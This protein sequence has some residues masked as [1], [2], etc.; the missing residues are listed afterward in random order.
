MSLETHTEFKDPLSFE[1]WDTTH[2]ATNETSIDDTMLRV[3]SAAASAEKTPELQ[4]YW[5]GQFLDMLSGFK[6]TSGG[7]IY[8][9]AGAGWSGTSLLNCFVS[10]RSGPDLDSIE[11]ILCDIGN[12]CKTLKSEGGWGQNFSWIRPRGSFIQKIGIESPGAVKFMEIYDKTSDVITSGSGQKAKA[13]KKKIR[14]GA[15]MGVLDV[16]HP[17][18]EE[19]IRAKQHGDRLQKFNLSSNCLDKFMQ[20]LIYL[21]SVKDKVSKEEFDQL[22]RWDLIFPEITHE[23]YDEEWDG[24]IS[25]WQAKGYPIEVYKTVSLTG[26]WDLIMENTYKRADPGVLFLDR[27]NYFNPLSYAEKILATNPCLRG[28]T[29]VSLK[30]GSPFQ[31]QELVDRI[32]SGEVLEVLTY[33]TATR[34]IEPDVV[35]SGQLTK[36]NAELLE[37]VL[38]D[39]KTLYVTPDHRIYTENRGWVEAQYL[40]E[41]DDIMTL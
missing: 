35:I 33:N 7:R 37:L 5:R 36:E 28:D 8:A 2:R 40:T 19:F 9:N 38:D 17:D 30:D 31:I 41:D 13:G 4:E 20:T 12:Q 32:N 3:A 22:D 16:W 14:K 10:P 39:G 29:R 11:G 27:A 23:R 18:I 24:D 21:L 25:A 1:I 6:C 15:M 26:L 34:K